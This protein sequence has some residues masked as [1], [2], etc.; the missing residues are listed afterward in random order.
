MNKFIEIA[1][2]IGSQ[3]HL[4]AIRDGFVSVMPLII[5]GSLA[6]LINNFPAI[7]IGGLSLAFVGSMN[8]MFGECNWQ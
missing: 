1:G 3:R 7:N 2:R 8:S 5:V 6:V 4:V